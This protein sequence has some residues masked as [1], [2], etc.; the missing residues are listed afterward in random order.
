[1]PSIRSSL[2]SR[3]TCAH[4]RRRR[5]ELNGLL[6][7]G[8]R[9]SVRRNSKAKLSC[10]LFFLTTANI[11]TT[12]VYYRGREL[13]NELFRERKPA[14]FISQR[15]A[16]ARHPPHASENVTGHPTLPAELGLKK[17][18]HGGAQ[19]RPRSIDRSMRNLS[20]PVHAVASPSP[21]DRWIKEGSTTDPDGRPAGT[22]Q[23]NLCSALLN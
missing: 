19:P 9:Q 4:Q 21:V 13:T 16:A 17:L 8:R 18:R 3:E 6:Q 1:M 10:N 14:L 15:S 22:R 23:R 2:G 7:H 20:I 11:T 5:V 12:V